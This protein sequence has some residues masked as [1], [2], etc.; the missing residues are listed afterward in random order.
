MPELW[1]EN[2]IAFV[3]QLAIAWLL[4]CRA[5]SKCSGGGCTNG[6]K[7]CILSSCTWRKMPT[8]LGGSLLG[9]GHCG[10]QAKFQNHR[11]TLP[12]RKTS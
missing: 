10:D 7:P 9:T 6:R 1:Y 5:A 11:R 2:A 3:C 12:S 8:K 4:C